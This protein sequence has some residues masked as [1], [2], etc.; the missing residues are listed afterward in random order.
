MTGFFCATLTAA[1]LRA[2]AAR[3]TQP[4]PDIAGRGGYNYDM[5]AA[6]STSRDFQALTDPYQREL[7]VHSY[8][9]LGSLDDAEDALQ[10]ALLRAWRG[11]DT[12]REQA[13]LRPW[14]YRIVTNVSLDMLASRKT[15]TLPTFVANAA[16]P[17][18]PLP[19]AQADPLW[20]EPLPDEYLAGQSPNPEAR[21]ELHESVSLA[22]LAALQQLPGRQR[23]VLILRDVL[24]WKAQEVAELLDTSVAAVNSALQRARSTLSDLRLEPGSTHPP[25]AAT[26]G[27]LNRYVQ[28]WEAGD[29]DGLVELLRHDA[30]LTM[31]P[32]PVWY[33]GRAAIGQFFERH[34]FA[35]SPQGRFRTALTRANGCPAVAIYQAGADGVYRPASLQVL[36]LAEGAIARADCYLAEPGKL[37]SKFKLPLTV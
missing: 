17:Q 19:A 9:F 31:P 20:L 34:L 32:L 25:D 29:V 27:L 11:L 14:L 1:R 26:A 23:A 13:A 16:D 8:R 7:L 30:I 5:H 18:A 15:R 21:Y 6:S 24:G 12:L 37:F 2:T 33:S 4:G 36:W 22:F 28:A 10:E 3:A 35:G